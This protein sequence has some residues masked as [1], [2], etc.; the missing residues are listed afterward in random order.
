MDIL[1]VIYDY[2]CKTKQIR[3]N[4]R[5]SSDAYSCY[6]VIHKLS[7]P[8]RMAKSNPIKT[9]FFELIEDAIGSK[10]MKQFIKEEDKKMNSGSDNK[11]KQD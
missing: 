6:M 5:E 10:A 1:G 9:W 11:P 3:S 7:N 2:F 4:S 8:L